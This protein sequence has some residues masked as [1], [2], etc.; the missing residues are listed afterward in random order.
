MGRFATVELTRAFVE[1]TNRATL[2]GRVVQLVWTAP[3]VPGVSGVR[4]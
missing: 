2:L 1:G 4:I 3:A